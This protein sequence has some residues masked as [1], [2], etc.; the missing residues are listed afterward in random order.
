MASTGSWTEALYVPL[1]YE[2]ATGIDHGMWALCFVSRF[3]PTAHEV[4]RVLGNSASINSGILGV[5]NSN[6]NSSYW[7]KGFMYKNPI[8]S[9][10]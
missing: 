4:P 7:I 5:N 1:I 10:S 2:H 9:G 3:T 8:E 6:T